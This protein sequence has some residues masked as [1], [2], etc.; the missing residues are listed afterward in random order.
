MRPA[1]S[2]FNWAQSTAFLLGAQLFRN[3]GPILVLFFLARLTDQATVGRY[4]LALAIAT[5]FFVFAQF[6]LRTVVLTLN[7]QARFTE[8]ISVQGATVVLAFSGASLFALFGAREILIAV[9][10]AGLL[11]AADAFSDLLSGAL[12]KAGKS[13]L[14]FLGSVIAAT[15]V[16]V[17]AA[18]TLFLTR[19]L[20]PTLAALAVASL[21]TAFF[22]MYLPARTVSRYRESPLADGVSYA[23]PQEIRR[24]VAA[25][26]PLGAS[27]AS[28]ALISTV[29]QYVV[30]LSHGEAETARFAILLYVYALA[31][32]IT[33][34]VAQAWIPIA[35]RELEV[36]GTK[37]SIL[38]IT[39]VSALRWT[40]LFVPFTELGLWLAA[41]LIPLTFGQDY[42]L[43]LAEA[44]P[45]GLAIVTLPIAHFFATS[46]SIKN[47][48]IHTLTLAVTSAAV[49]VGV[50]LLLIPGAGVAGAFWALF[51]SVV[52][53]GIS[54][55]AVL[56]FRRETPQ[57]RSNNE[58]S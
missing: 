37:K 14:V 19:E 12:Q 57:T 22:F 23:R 47:Y 24:I 8:Y 48:Y 45:L 13:N 36:R 53:R 15:A 51:S 6:G 7:P 32:I 33:G 30:T 58:E 3:L 4:S 39:A 5:P 49:S 50:G 11:K 54:A 38:R 26:L 42:T 46:V 17:A 25:G 34:T 28:L 1:P 41:G 31:D 56:S 55:V 9:L 43:S 27:M 16:A 20:L 29:P 21:A 18:V 52:V 10:L 40:A 2:Q 35:Q 44:I